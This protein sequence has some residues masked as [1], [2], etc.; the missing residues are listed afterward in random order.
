MNYRYYLEKEYYLAMFTLSYRQLQYIVV[1]LFLLK[2]VE[3]PGI[4]LI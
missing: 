2:I 4:T 1:K 3:S